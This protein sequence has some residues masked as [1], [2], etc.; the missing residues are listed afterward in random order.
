M[1][2]DDFSFPNRI[3]R[4]VA[5]LEDHP[6]IDLVSSFMLVCDLRAVGKMT[7]PTSHD[8]LTAKPSGC[9][10][11]FHGAWLGRAEWFKRFRY[12][13]DCPLSQD[14]DL[15]FRSYRLSRFAVIPELLYAYRHDSLSLGNLSKSRFYRLPGDQ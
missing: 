9:I 15:L 6:E 7:A 4:Q 2:A 3:E 14:Q 1:D 8:R 11:V 13:E 12:D 5:F 10:R